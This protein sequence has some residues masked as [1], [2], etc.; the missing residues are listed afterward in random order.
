[1]LTNQEQYERGRALLE[2]IHG[3]HAG[4]ALVAAQREIC[5]DF[6]AMSIE[7]A[8]GGITARPGLDLRT[9]QL[10]V[11]AACTTLGHAT[12]QLAAHIEGAVAVGA[13][14]E[15]IVESI[16]QTLFYAGGAAVANAV[17]IANEVLRN[18]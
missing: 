13:T 12:P 18:R 5:P 1:M 8:M 2:K 7:W 10:L 14:R 3:G 15:E 16:L 6:A 11:I 4:D 9:R 17:A